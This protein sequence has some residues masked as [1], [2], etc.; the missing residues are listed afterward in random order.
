[1]SVDERLLDDYERELRYLRGAGQAFAQAHPKVAGRLELSG[2]QCAD[3]HV[4]RLLEAFAF[5]AARIHR[6]I[7]DSVSDVAT[8]LLDQ[9]FPHALRPVP[10]A[11]VARFDADPAGVP[12]TG[13]PV[14]R[15]ST[16][17]A[18]SADGD[19][20]Y[21]QTSYP[22]TLW[23][24]TLGD[25]QLRTT[26]L[27]RLT[28]LGAANSALVLPLAYPKA[29]AFDLAAAG[30]GARPLLRFCVR[31]DT[32]GA[33]QLCDLLLGDTLEVRWRRAPG[34]PLRTLD[35]LPQPVGLAPD[36]AML[37]ERDDT[38]EAY[39]LLVEYFAFPAKFQFFDLDC[40]ALD[41]E[42]LAGGCGELVFVFARKPV[43]ALVLEAGAVLLGCTPVLNLFPR[44][45]EP[46][47]VTGRQAQYTLVADHH[48]LRSTEIYSI[49]EV[50][51]PEPGR[52]D[53][54]L[55][56]YYGP[57]SARPA[58]QG[59]RHWHA[60]RVTH[61]GGQGSD[62]LLTFVDPDFE[63]ARE[64][65]AHTLHAQVLCTNRQLARQLPA[66]AR[67]ESE[68]AGAIATITALHKPS[69]QVQPS[70]DGEAR[71]RLVSQLSLNQ[72]SLVDGRKARDCLC[73]LLTLNNL[74][75]ELAAASQI[76]GILSLNCQRVARHVGDDPWEGY[77]QGY[78][79][80][81][82]LDT[83]LFRGSSRILFGAVLHRFL[84]LFAG[85]NTFVE[86]TIRD[87]D[88]AV[89]KNWPALPARQLRL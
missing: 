54:T 66:G 75:G 22:V 76:Q 2:D 47:R 53:Q 24:L 13:Y 79:V 6:N 77:R 57:R 37:P 7:D 73:E 15:G 42:Q 56:A 28:T 52:A 80:N 10:S 35:V 46:L 8:S 3:P 17:F 36:Q 19:T 72:L 12:N 39:R 67:L 41:F 18:R 61:P 20:V 23:P 84:A 82:R 34:A 27:I 71:W 68:D 31:G 89:L 40:A 48:R 16:L 60:Q 81:V 69:A 1:M 88:G 58:G 51:C 11:T 49:E 5:L 29:F 14:A 65:G 63:P 87:E 55:H 85:V 38:H 26:E 25:A 83:A 62:M 74:T 86:L 33:A 30:P 9:L 44:T 50:S 4:E 32:D 59:M 21:F 43:R 70:L 45:A 78:A 64:T